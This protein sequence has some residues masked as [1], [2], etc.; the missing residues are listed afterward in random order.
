MRIEFDKVYVNRTPVE[1]SEAPFEAYRELAYEA[2][3]RLELDL[4]DE[5]V[6]TLAQLL[7]MPAEEIAAVKGFAD[8]SSERIV[9]GLQKKIPLIEK[10]RGLGVEPLQGEP[11]EEVDGVLNEKTFCFTGAIQRI[12][13]L[14][15]KRLTRKQLEERV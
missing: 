10:L 9:A 13:P 4:P 15:E 11:A 14:T 1:G 2:L 6:I 12:D 5:G 3:T 8:I 7:E